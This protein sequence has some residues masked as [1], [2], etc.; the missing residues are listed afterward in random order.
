M[1]QLSD[2]QDQINQISMEER[3]EDNLRS[4]I[5]GIQRDNSL[6]ASEKARRIQ[7]VMMGKFGG[8]GDHSHHSH[9]SHK[10]DHSTDEKHKDED[11]DGGGGITVS[12]ISRNNTDRNRETVVMT[13][14]QAEKT[15]HDELEKT[16]L[17]C[18]HYMRGAKIQAECCGEWFT[19]RMC[20][21]ETEQHKITRYATKTMMCMHCLTA[22]PSAQDCIN[23]GTMLGG[24]YYCDICKLWDSNPD[25]SIYH[26]DKCGLC[27]VGRGLGEDYFHCDNC[28]RRIIL[29][30]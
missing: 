3:T 1:D 19:C 8:G 14:K 17:G 6:S 4:R 20:H 30:E 23:C 10:C 28:E 9:H 2:V 18:K 21:D 27:R 12:Y 22:Q 25:R 5:F 7:S 15:Y 26:C 13:S 24:T 16:I 29:K 11:K